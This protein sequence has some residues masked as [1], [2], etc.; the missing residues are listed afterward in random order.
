MK[1]KQQEIDI[2]RKER[3]L[4]RERVTKAASQADQAEQSV[5]SI[6]KEYEKVDISGVEDKST[7]ITRSLNRDKIA[8]VFRHLSFL[9]IRL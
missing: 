8:G 4:E 2:L 6:K 5:L 1:E 3:D 9:Y 7:T